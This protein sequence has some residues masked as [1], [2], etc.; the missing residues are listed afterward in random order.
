MRDCLRNWLLLWGNPN[1][2]LFGEELW[3]QVG[4][5]LSFSETGEIPQ[6]NLDVVEETVV[7]AEEAA[8][9]IPRKREKQEKKRLKTE[10][11]GCHCPGIT[12]KKQCE[13]CEETNERP[14]EKQKPQKAPQE[15]G[16]ENPSVFFSKP[17]KRKPFSKKEVVSS[18]LE[19]TAVEVFP[20]GRNLSPKR[21]QLVT[22]KSQET[23]VPEKKQEK[24]FSKGKPPHSEP[25]DAAASRRGSSKR[26]K[27]LWKLSQ[28]KQN[29]HFPSGA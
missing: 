19:E 1:S 26:K 12:R 8:D 25:E 4:E 24:L 28:K 9:E 3:K 22:W 10:K 23:R 14:K 21:N 6:K 7:Q 11:T 5:W 27:T 18:D 15:D 17:K 13:E 20:S 16:M 29:G 2:Q